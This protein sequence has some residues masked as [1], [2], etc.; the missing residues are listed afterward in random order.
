MKVVYLA[1]LRSLDMLPSQRGSWLVGA[2]S[3][4]GVCKAWSGLT[5]LWG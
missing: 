1:F 3:K 2:N 4:E 5:D